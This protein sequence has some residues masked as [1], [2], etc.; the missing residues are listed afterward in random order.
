MKTSSPPSLHL[1][2]IHHP[3][4]NRNGEVISSAITNLDLHDIARAAR[5][6]GAKSYYV[7]TPLEDQ[8][9]MAARIVSH[10]TEGAGAGHNPMRR[11]ALEMIRVR[12]CL[13][14]VIAEI[15]AGEGAPRIVA[16]SARQDAACISFE[17][18]RQRLAGGRPHLLL[19]GTAW[20]L[21]EEVLAAADDRLAPIRA[22]AGYNHL[23]VRSAAAVI[24]DRLMGDTEN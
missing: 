10:W 20:G 14:E 2:L 1:A 19:L 15:S 21:A 16:T 9:R 3:V 5:T 8:A 24:L 17:G 23:S 18:L 12:D 13:E 4:L 7:V 6:Y 22:G 11:A